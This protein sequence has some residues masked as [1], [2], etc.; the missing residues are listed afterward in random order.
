MEQMD[1]KELAKTVAY[2]INSYNFDNKDFCEQM[3]REHRTL[4][5][6]FMRL[7][8]EYLKSTAE[9]EYYDG[10]NEASVMFARKVMESVDPDDM[11]LPF[12]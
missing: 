2:A 11:K 5:Q 3:H 1:G 4:Q 12:I 8:R 9:T 10:R 6:N 7:I